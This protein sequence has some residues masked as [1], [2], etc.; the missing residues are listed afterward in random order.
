MIDVDV[1]IIG[2]GQAGAP[3]SWR[4]ART[5]RSVALVERA[6]L[7]GTCV[8][9]GCTPTKT[10]IASAAAAHAARRAS[11]LGV[12]T[13]QVEVDMSRVG[14]R[15]REVVEQWRSGVASNIEDAGEGLRLVRG[16]ARFTGPRTVEVEDRAFRA[17]TVIVN[18]GARPRI[19]DVPGLAAT[20]FLTNRT[21]LGLQEV[22]D[23]LVVL[24]GGFVGCELGQAFYRLGSQ[25]TLLQSGSQLLPRED[26]DVAGA[27]QK[28]LEGEGIDIRLERRVIET[29]EGGDGVVVVAEGG[30]PVTG[31]HLLV[32]AGRIPN[33]DDLGAEAGGIELD[34][35][36]YVRVDERYR[37]SAEGVYAVGDCT[38][39][40]QFTHTSWDDHRILFDL[41]TGSTERRRDGRLVPSSTFTDPQLARVGLSE[42]EARKAGK[43]V[44]VATL[45]FS[46][47]ARAYETGRTAGLVKVLVDPESERILGAAIVGAEAAELV[48]VFQMLMEADAPA[49]V[50][51]DAQ[52]IHPAFVEGLQSAVM[53]LDRYALS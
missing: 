6:E 27:L 19:P 35:D 53:S 33:T 23:H 22:P 13:G 10:F 4:L 15:I 34:A 42:R 1:L 49:T 44:E 20:P 11:L 16:H 29:G 31:S 43:E 26:E 5:G 18:T 38:G 3:L 39:G 12:D 52:M 21:A 14:A 36:G 8:N 41:L 17:E 30:G 2:S 47:I 24:G 50:L 9:T 32:A 45:P 25:V 40:P 46:R 28:A 7:G 37:T 51:V 48:T